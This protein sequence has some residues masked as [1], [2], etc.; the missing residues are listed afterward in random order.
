MIWPDLEPPVLQV[1]YAS[2]MSNFSKTQMESCS[3]Y[4]DKAF[5]C[6]RA[7]ADMSDPAGRLD[8]LKVAHHWLRLAEHVGR[9]TQPTGP[10]AAYI[11][12]SRR[13]EPTG[14]AATASADAASVASQ[15]LVS[16]RPQSSKGGGRLQEEVGKLVHRVRAA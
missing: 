1:R 15:V 3:R 4:R 13:G 5:E 9:R 12:G 11:A 8:L 2:D 6:L 16:T 14:S 7:L 10:E